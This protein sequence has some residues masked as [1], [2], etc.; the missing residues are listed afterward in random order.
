VKSHQLVRTFS[1]LAAAAVLSAGLSTAGAEAATSAAKTYK[2]CTELNKVYKHGV[3][4]SG[5]KDHVSGSSKPVTT[6]TR[7]AAVY[8]ANTKSDRDKDKIACEKK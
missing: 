4:L 8:N 7:N 3:G 1:V 5:A 2:N 6:F